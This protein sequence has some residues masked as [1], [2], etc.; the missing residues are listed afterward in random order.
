[1]AQSSGCTSLMGS[2]ERPCSGVWCG[3]AAGICSSEQ[4]ALATGGEERRLSQVLEGDAHCSCDG[5]AG[6]VASVASGVSS[7][8]FSCAFERAVAASS[9]MISITSR[10]TSQRTWIVFFLGVC[11]FASASASLGGFAF[12]AETS[13]QGVFSVLP[14]S[15]TAV[16]LQ[17]SK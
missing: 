4:T 14:I 12:S 10:L 3:T 15:S 11:S 17:W 7:P 9:V 2:L 16:S 8:L 13:L 1:M 6:S 5:V